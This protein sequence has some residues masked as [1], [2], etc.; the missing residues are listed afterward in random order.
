MALASAAGGAGATSKP[1]RPNQP[2]PTNSVR[3]PSLVSS[4]AAHRKQPLTQPTTM[5]QQ[6]QPR[7]PAT[8]VPAAAPPPIKTK[9]KKPHIPLYYDDPSLTPQQ[10]FEMRLQ[11]A[12]WRQRKRRRERRRQRCCGMTHMTMAQH[13]NIHGM[14]GM[15]GGTS[16]QQ[17]A[18]QQA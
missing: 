5:T 2:L 7:Q 11:E 6:Q 3:R 14:V 18:Q 13:T 17:Q 9:S 16:H 8:A 4:N 10:Q 12:R 15:Q 1:P